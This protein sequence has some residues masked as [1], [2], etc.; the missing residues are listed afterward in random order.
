MATNT[1]VPIATYTAT[2]SVSTYTFSS[3]PATYTDLILVSNLSTAAS[4]G[5]PSI[6][7]NGDTAANY[8]FTTLYGNGTTAS[9]ARDSALTYLYFAVATSLDTTYTE[10]LIVQIQ[11]YS[12]T[13]TYKTLLARVNKASAGVE[14]TVG[15][16]KAT[17]AAINSLTIFTHNGQNFSSTSTFSLYG[18]L[19]EVG[20][21]TPKATGGVVTSDATYYYHTFLT[22]GNFVPNQSLSCDVLRVA[23]GGS[24]GMTYGNQHAGGGGAGG[25]LYSTS[26]ALTATNYSVL[27]GAGGAGQTVQLN[28]GY[29]GS[30]TIFGS[31]TAA[32]GGGYGARGQTEAAGNGGS[33]GGGGGGDVVARTGGT[34]SQGSNGGTGGAL[35]TAAAGGGG[36]SAAGG[37]ASG[38]AGG[39]G[40]AGTNTYSTFASVTGTGVSGYYAGGGGGTGASSQGAGGAGGGTAAVNTAIG[41]AGTAN[42]GGGSGGAYGGNGYP[43]GNGGSGIVIVRYAK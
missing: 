21:S 29:A 38:N 1:Y 14:A 17:P 6:R 31:L 22:S 9:S 3:I 13:T 16:W 15:L 20:G 39:A 4:T 24:G 27:V 33:G 8:S 32:T 18:I 7:F 28:T 36:Y 42:T 2:G 30:T 37:S 41:T 35:S 25:L 34:G 43:S 26:Q 12:N 40:G 11:N 19:A 5:N 23:G 10:N